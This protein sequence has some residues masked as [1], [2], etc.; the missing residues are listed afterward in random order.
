MSR[1]DTQWKDRVATAANRAFGA[2]VSLERGGSTL[3]SF[4]ARRTDR[5]YDVFAD[6]APP[7]KAQMVEFKF[8]SDD[9]AGATPQAGDRITDNAEVFEAMPLDSKPAVEY[10]KAIDEYTVRTKKVS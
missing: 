3:A 6:D 8:N 4:T 2:S 7:T 1:F 9:L 10:R 5:E